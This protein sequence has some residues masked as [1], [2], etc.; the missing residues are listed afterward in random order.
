MV[1][2]IAADEIKPTYTI[3]YG[4]LET[5]PMNG[6]LPDAL[7]KRWV[8]VVDRLRAPPFSVLA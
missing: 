3:L 5:S 1:R 2:Q 8:D 4:L 6:I 7:P